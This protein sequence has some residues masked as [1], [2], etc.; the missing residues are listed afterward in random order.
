MH[1]HDRV[2]TLADI[3]TCSSRLQVGSY[4]RLGKQK[5]LGSHIVAH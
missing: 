3:R 1:L 4:R 5:R 2:G